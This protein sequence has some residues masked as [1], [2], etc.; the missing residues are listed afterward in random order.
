MLA[1]RNGRHHEQTRA[2]PYRQLTGIPCGGPAACFNVKMAASVPKVTQERA[3]TSP[4]WY[5]PR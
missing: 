4:I 3:F 2:N 5:T 1:R